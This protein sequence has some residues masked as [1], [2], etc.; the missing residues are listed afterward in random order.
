MDR[1][2]IGIPFDNSPGLTCIDDTTPAGVS[3][4]R[5]M[6]VFHPEMLVVAENIAT[7]LQSDGHIVTLLP[8]P[9]SKEA[10]IKKKAAMWLRS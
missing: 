2:K 7:A 3:S 6:T 1:M 8:L 10:Q 4:Y 9:P 5:G